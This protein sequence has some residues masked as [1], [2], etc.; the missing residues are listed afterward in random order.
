[1]NGRKR[2]IAIRPIHYISHNYNAAADG[3]DDDDNFLIS[4]SK[5]S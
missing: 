5:L 4:V 1:M 2:V 3:D